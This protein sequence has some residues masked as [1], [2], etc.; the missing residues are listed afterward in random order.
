MLPTVVWLGSDKFY[1]AVLA[2]KVGYILMAS[3]HSPMKR[4]RTVSRLCIYVGIILQKP[5]SRVFAPF[6]GGNVRWCI[7]AMGFGVYVSFSCQ[8]QYGYLC[9][10]TLCCS[11]E[12]GHAF[13]ISRVHVGMIGH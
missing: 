1:A 11:V 2:K 3:G 5:L 9:V 7:A 6:G 10:T 4:G 12:R 13:I 8:K